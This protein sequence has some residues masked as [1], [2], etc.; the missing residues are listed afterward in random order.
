MSRAISIPGRRPGTGWP[1]AIAPNRHPRSGSPGSHGRDYKRH[2]HV[3]HAD[4]DPDDEGALRDQGKRLGR[5]TRSLGCGF[6]IGAHLTDESIG[7]QL[8]GQIGHASWSIGPSLWRAAPVRWAAVARFAAI[9]SVDCAFWWSIDCGLCLV[10]HC[11]GCV[12]QYGT[13][14]VGSGSTSASAARGRRA[15][16]R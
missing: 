1:Q 5:P 10:Y 9:A 6:E 14:M 12:P 3:A 13:E 16:P 8:G 2:P 15:I 7:H 11:H 4:M